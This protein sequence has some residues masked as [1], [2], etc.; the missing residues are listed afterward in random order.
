MPVHEHLKAKDGEDNDDPTPALP[1]ESTGAAEDARTSSGGT[2]LADLKSTGPLP[3]RSGIKKVAMHDHVKPVDGTGEDNDDPNL[4]SAGESSG[5]SEDASTA[6]GDASLAELKRKGPEGT[7]DEPQG[8]QLGTDDPQARTATHSTDKDHPT[9]VLNSLTEVNM[10]S[11]DV[12]ANLDNVSSH[13]F[14][15]DTLGIRDAIHF[16]NISGWYHDPRNGKDHFTPQE[17]QNYIEGGER[18]IA[19]R[20]AESG[21]KGCCIYEK[22]IVT[23]YTSDFDGQEKQT[24]SWKPE[25]ADCKTEALCIPFF[26]QHRWITM[27]PRDRRNQVTTVTLYPDENHKLTFQWM[28]EMKSYDGRTFRKDSCEGVVE[29]YGSCLA[30][31][32]Q[33]QY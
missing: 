14:S 15:D 3:K 29:Y 30:Y 18:Y 31:N 21:T 8:D 28:N 9:A 20:V 10:N 22:K 12:H 6:P 2:S 4:V 11:S 16:P 24:V 33:V 19:R 5:A 23:T 1:G 7:D 17:R 32:P 13:E 25:W 26:R 27:T